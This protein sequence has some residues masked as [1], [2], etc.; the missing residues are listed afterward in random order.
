MTEN[1]HNP[2]IQISILGRIFGNVNADEV[3]GQ[4]ITLKSM[5]SSD[6]ETHPFVSPRAVKYCIRQAF[7]ERG[8]EVDNF[9]LAGD[10]LI[11]SGDPVKYVDNDLFG[12]MKAPRGTREIAQRRQAPIA[13]SYFK[14][15]RDTPVRSELGLRAPRDKGNPLPF[16]IEVAEFIGRIN[17]LIYDYIGVY[18][19]TEG[20]VKQGEPFIE[21]EERRKR[22]RAFLEIFMTPTYVLPR[23]TNSLNVPEYIVGLVVLSKTGPLPVYQYLD[24]VIE[25]NVPIVDLSKIKLLESREDLRH[26]RKVLVDYEN[27]V[28]EECPLEVKSLNE[29]IPEMVDFLLP[30]V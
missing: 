15:L 23:R 14:A 30:E 17:C 18:T 24:Y 29:I 26:A 4:R 1:T 16:E 2:V 27:A 3:I 22:L 5:Y 20:K 7:R 13:I 25:G 19:G 8:Y 28:P 10:R 9:E 12:F 11:D 21:N 6:G